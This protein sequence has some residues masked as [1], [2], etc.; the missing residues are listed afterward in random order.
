MSRYE[1]LPTL[2]GEN[3]SQVSVGYSHTAAVKRDG[4]LWTWGYQGIWGKLG[5]GTDKK[6]ILWPTKI[7]DGFSQALAGYLNTAAVKTDGTLWLWGA[8]GM[9]GDCTT[10]THTMPVQVGENFVQAALRGGPLLALK[11]DGSEWTYGWPW[12]GDQLDTPRACRKPTRVVFGDGVS[13]WDKPAKETIKAE[14]NKPP[15][16]ADIMAIAAGGSH[17]AMV[18]ADGTL[19]TWGNNEYG[20][21]ALGTTQNHNRPQKAGERFA[22]VSINDWYTLAQKTDGSLL[23][24]GAIPT[25]YPRGDFS[26]NRD[27]AL[28]PTRIF[29]GT[30]VLLRRGHLSDT[31]RGLGLGKDGAI[32]E[33]GYYSETS[34]PPQV[35]GHEV[36]EIGS[37]A[38]GRYAIRNDGSLWELSGY[39]SYPPRQFGKDF[40]N[41]AVGPNHAYAIKADGSLWAWGDNDVYQLGDGT[42]TKRADPVRIGEGFVQIAA[43]RYHGIA[44]ASDGSVWTW[45]N[46]EAG[47]IGDGKNMPAC[48]RPVK[49]GTGFAMIAAGDYHNI[50]VKTDG[51][52]WAWGANN[53]GQLG[54][55]TNI[56]RSSPVQIYPEP[57]ANSKE[58]APASLPTVKTKSAKRAV[59]AIYVDLYY[60]CASFSDG[61]LECWGCW[62]NGYRCTGP[63]HLTPTVVENKGEISGWPRSSRMIDCGKS[64][65]EC[66]GVFSRLA[67][68]RGASAIVN[69]HDLVCA[70]KNGTIRCARRDDGGS[71]R[72][73]VDGIHDAIMFDYRGEHGCALLSDG[74]VKCW[75]SNAHGELGN[76][77]TDTR[78]RDRPLATEVVNLEP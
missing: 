18:K 66:D 75:G 72:H 7:G 62:R 44:L 47:V 48:A 71:S 55:G 25:T 30:V 4:S 38:F 58:N 46:N 41:I 49:I 20:Q 23:R 21:L 9:F 43:G 42:Q 8:G 1:S 32:F 56:S 17:S 61:Q 33:W 39:P 67:F 36:R 26:K 68:L 24:W 10:T 31:G 34:K 64:K 77:T 13:G 40:L 28:A 63:K 76:G 78:Y 73:I 15:M 29:D 70:L 74:R 14:L 19:W 51:S 37:G 12:E 54:D 27:K 2:V 11:Q 22:R 6:K 59:T 3:F 60:S 65:M 69:G 16:P 35:F 52:V 53:D 57:L 50:A 5:D 45:G